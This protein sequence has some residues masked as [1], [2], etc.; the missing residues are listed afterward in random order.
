MIL[1]ASHEL[2]NGWTKLTFDIS[3][4][5]SLLERGHQITADIS[6]EH[7]G[8]HDGDQRDAR[9]QQGVLGHNVKY[10]LGNTSVFFSL[11]LLCHRCCRQRG[12]G[13]LSSC[14][15]WCSASFHI[16]DRTA[17]ATF[18]P[19][20]WVGIAIP[21]SNMW[22]LWFIMPLPCDASRVCPVPVLKWEDTR[23]AINICADWLF[24]G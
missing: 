1:K 22:A 9:A 24:W 19:V 17:V 6:K 3:L 14:R 2:F 18:C 8:T 5:I 4:Q 20:F 13:F 11:F 12:R 16:G 15:P 23:P 10:H 7:H 21:I